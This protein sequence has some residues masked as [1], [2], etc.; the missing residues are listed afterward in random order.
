VQER[1]LPTTIADLLEAADGVKSAV[2]V[3]FVSPTIAELVA[4]SLT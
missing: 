3:P 4:L 2:S 1:A